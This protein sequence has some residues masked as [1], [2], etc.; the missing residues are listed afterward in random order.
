MLGHEIVSGEFS[1][2]IGDSYRVGIVRCPDGKLAVGGGGIDLEFQLNLMTSTP[3]GPAGWRAEFRPKYA[4]NA[5]GIHR[6]MT[7]AV[8]VAADE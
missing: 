8:C 7:Y 2:A 6:F 5:T 1:I 4:G 3:E